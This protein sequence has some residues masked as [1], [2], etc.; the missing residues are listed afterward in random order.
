VS[1]ADGRAGERGS[2]RTLT[3]RAVTALLAVAA[4]Q[5]VAAPVFAKVSPLLFLGPLAGLAAALAVDEPV[6][7]AAASAVG[8]LLGSLLAQYALVAGTAP[9]LTAALGPAAIAAAVGA[10]VTLLLARSPHLARLVAAGAVALLIL[11]AWQSTVVID[12]TPD[13]SGATF[14]SM[15]RTPPAIGPNITDEAIYALYV[16]RTAA[17]QDYYRVVGDVLQEANRTRSTPYD[18]STPLSFRLPTLYWTLSRLPQDGLSLILAA[19]AVA[20]AA[21][22]AAYALARRFVGPAL[23]LVAAAGVMAYLS[24]LATTPLFLNSEGWAGALGLVSVALLVA[25]LDGPEADARLLWA[26]AAAG[27][28]AA[29]VRELGAAFLVVGLLASLVRSDAR[30]SRAW[31]PFVA[32]IAGF[33]AVLGVHWTAASAV[34]RTLE[35]RPSDM[36]S[37]FQPDGLGLVALVWRTTTQ[38]ALR[39]A[40]GWV[41]LALG[42]F[43]A[44]AA[45]RD[46]AVRVALALPAV[47]APLLLLVIRPPGW[48]P[49]INLPATHW[50]QLV[51][52]S[53]LACVPLAAA[54]LLRGAGQR[55]QAA[56]KPEPA[57]AEAS[58]D[59]AG[60]GASSSVA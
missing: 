29:S 5:L 11:G 40:L 19:L 14:A 17:G 33:A 32:A 6:R 27:L 28:L 59:S 13:A 23:G 47:C 2:A 26:S 49:S 46:R 35:K 8:V 44:L 41:L 10:L 3:G 1:E 21:A 30:R 34:I 38:L 56:P 4:L 36:G 7:A 42:M 52:P 15:L 18:V 25:G 55:D 48:V 54:V 24:S 39:N 20:S 12:T 57:A 45:S 9:A 31:L 43:G 58:S 60:E 37:Y 51:T 53:V 50:T 16:G 22:V